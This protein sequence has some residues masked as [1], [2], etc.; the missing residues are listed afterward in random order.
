MSREI[1]G[2]INTELKSLGYDFVTL[3]LAGLK[4]GSLNVVVPI[5]NDLRA[6]RSNP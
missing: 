4:S 3:D 5:V 6:K 1:F 2:T